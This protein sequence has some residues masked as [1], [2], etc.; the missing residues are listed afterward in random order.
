MG[1]SSNWMDSDEEWK[2]IWKIK[3]PG[4][5]LIHLWRFAHDCLPSG[6]QLCK[7]RV[8]ASGLSQTIQGNCRRYILPIYIALFNGHDA[9]NTSRLKL[10]PHPRRHQQRII[11]ATQDGA[12]LVAACPAVWE[13]A[14]ETW[15]QRSG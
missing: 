5:M 14:S 11:A 7:R 6:F 13:G 3:A 10:L 2:S 15:R 1:I 12:E 4:K 8:P 9:T